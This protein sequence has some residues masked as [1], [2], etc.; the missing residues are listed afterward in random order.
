MKHYDGE[1]KLSQSWKGYKAIGFVVPHASTLADKLRVL[2]GLDLFFGS[3]PFVKTTV[4]VNTIVWLLI[5]Q[6]VN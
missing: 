1:I 4:L 6:G 3:V 5:W 2:W